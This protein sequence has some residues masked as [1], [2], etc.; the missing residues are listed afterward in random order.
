[1]T[2]LPQTMAQQILARASGKEHVCVGDFVTAKVDTLMMTDAFPMIFRLL[3]EVGIE[4]LAD[5][6][7]V[8][9]VFDHEAPAPTIHA[10]TE[11][12]VGRG[13]VQRLGIPRFHD[14]NSG[15]GHQVMIEQGYVR[16]GDLTL[17]SDSHATMYGAFGSAG[18]G[19]GFSEGA[20]VLATG[21]LWFRVP[22]TIAIN[23]RGVLQPF[24]GTKDLML[25]LAGDYGTDVANYRAIEFRGPGA[26][27]LDMSQR[28]TMANM[29][30]ELG[31]KFAMF[32]ADQMTADYFTQRGLPAPEAFGADIGAEY[33][34]TIEID[35]NKLEPQVSAPGDVGNAVNVS[36]V[37]GTHVD[38]VF[39][40][41]C[42]NA[43]F[44]DLAVAAALLSGRKVAAGTRLLVTPASAEVYRKA[45]TSGVLATLA[46]AGATISPPGCG[47]CLGGHMGLL[48]PDEVCISTS[49][50][51]FAGR[52]G[53]A[54]AKIFLSSPHVAAA[55]AI[56]G[57]IMDPREIADA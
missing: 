5:P 38:Q 20:W 46:E 53:S 26:S 49:N 12:V 36:V 22:P 42:T 56:A 8:V 55:S 51:N 44:D 18:C 9:V 32:E 37:S 34:R 6:E 28:M 10:A 54:S 31:A 3:E 4:K 14:A 24:V 21:E 57:R 48:G 2:L 47:P 23:L 30:V 17:A 13:L 45:A 19:V 43:R 29:G 41:S 33:E 50:R 27:M 52:M 16:P 39:I 35:L 40:G 25:R 1:M 11:H 7:R 15:V